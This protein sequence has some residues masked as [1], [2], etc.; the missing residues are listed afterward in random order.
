MDINNLKSIGKI[1]RAVGL[2]GELEIKPHAGNNF[3]FGEGDPLFIEIN[4]SKIPFFITHVQQT[5]DRYRV[6]FDDISSQEDAKKFSNLE[7]FGI[8]QNIIIKISNKRDATIIGYKAIDKQLGELGEITDIHEYPGQHILAINYQ[9][10]EILLPVT[11][12]FITDV[13]HKT[14]TVYIHCPDGLLEVYGK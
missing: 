9:G 3:P 5:G 8:P 10:K 12:D 7:I 1:T 14:A 13:D 6:Q 11:E 4:K 2:S